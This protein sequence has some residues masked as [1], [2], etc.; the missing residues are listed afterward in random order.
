MDLGLNERRVL[1]T[2]GTRGIGLAAAKLFA[3]E[4]ARVA[5][6]YS[7]SAD[8]AERVVAEE[9]GGPDRALAV[10]YELRE[11]ESI[12]A[13]MRTVE[14]RFGG[15]DVLVANAL[16]FTWSGPDVGPD[17]EDVPAD[18]WMT[19][20][21]ANTEAHMLTAQRAVGGMR[22][23]G[24]GRIVLLSSITAHHGMPKSEIYSSSKAALHGF[25]R[26][27]MWTRKG[28]LVNVVAPGLTM[29]E[30][31]REMAADSANDEAFRQET[32]KT[33][34]GRL[35][36]PIDIARLVVFL[37]SEANGNINGEVI[38]TAGGR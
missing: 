28:V 11:R 32:D 3:A 34:S 14:D 17:F 7:T 23:R 13:A 4:G 24:W 22:E 19:R 26:G 36:D 15:V 12:E 20:F 33:P 1:V 27:L 21:R 30:S 25:A 10:R 6:T 29:T 9:L 38:H 37:G 5:I 2:G 18:A 31:V 35:S 8:E 16:W